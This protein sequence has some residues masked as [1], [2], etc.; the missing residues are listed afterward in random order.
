MFF[1]FLVMVVLTRYLKTENYTN[2]YHDLKQ[3]VYENVKYLYGTKIDA[4]KQ[5]IGHLNDAIEK[6]KHI[7]NER[8]CKK[9]SKFY[10][11]DHL[12]AI[13]D[14]KR[15]YVV[16]SIDTSNG[17]YS[18][19]QNECIHSTDESY[20]TDFHCTK[21]FNCS[22]GMLISGNKIMKDSKETCVYDCI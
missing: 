3:H 7:Y 2:Y 6:G 22:D 18:G 17:T 12:N 15:T 10:K 16:P 13:K 14:E 20:S 19:D 5:H 8:F 4:S 1:I 21:K 11:V 9:Y